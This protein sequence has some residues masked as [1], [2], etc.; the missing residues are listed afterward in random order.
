MYQAPP[1]HC[2][3]VV[4]A[5]V[6]EGAPAR[7][8][9]VI[10]HAIDQVRTNGGSFGRTQFGIGTQVCNRRPDVEGDVSR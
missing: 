4:D 7:M 9:S 2:S 1:I 6:T 3:T 5:V 10:E 8:R